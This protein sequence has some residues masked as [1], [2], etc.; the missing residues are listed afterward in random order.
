MPDRHPLG[1]SCRRMLPLVVL[2][3][4]YA[5]ARHGW[6]TWRTRRGGVR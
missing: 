5:I 1:R 4:P 3:M 2:L 6:D